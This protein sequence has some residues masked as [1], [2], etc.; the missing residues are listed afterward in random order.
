EMN[1]EFAAVRG[2]IAALREDMDREFAA[3]RGEIATLRQDMDRE[4]ATLRTEIRKDLAALRSEINA[5]IAYSQLATIVILSA[6][7][8]AFRLFG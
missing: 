2:E 7:M 6:V 4:F 8:G 3:V 1:R 5:R